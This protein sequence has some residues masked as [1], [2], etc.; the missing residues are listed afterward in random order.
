MGVVYFDLQK[1]P[2][3]FFSKF[4]MTLHIICFHIYSTTQRIT[5][6]Q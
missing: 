2:V 1:H 5:I 6:V 3:N 4:L